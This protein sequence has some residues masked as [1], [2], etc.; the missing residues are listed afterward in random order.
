MTK[1]FSILN[2]LVPDSDQIR[3]LF[4]QTNTGTHCADR[5]LITDDDDTHVDGD[6]TIT[7]IILLVLLVL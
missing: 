6:D 5:S 7:N 1:I 4:S 2:D 3:F